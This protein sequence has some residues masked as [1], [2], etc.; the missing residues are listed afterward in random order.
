MSPA[1]AGGRRVPGPRRLP[2]LGPVFPRRRLLGAS[3][4]ALLLFLGGCA[5]RLA[6][7]PRTGRLQVITTTGIL[8][9]LAHNVGGDRIDVVSLV[10]D[11]GDPHSYEA[12]LRDARNVVYADVALSN[13]AML[14][15]QNVIKTLDSNLRDEALNVSLAEDSAKYAAE[16]IP[17]VEDVRLDTVWLGLRASGTGSR[18]GATRSSQVILSA[19]EASGPG[20]LFAYLTGSFGETDIYFDSSDSFQS[21]DGY[22]SDSTTLPA[23]AHTHLSWAFTRPGTY[24]LTLRA[25]LQ[26]EETD[27]PVE[28]G[29]ATYTFAVGVDPEKAAVGAGIRHPVIVRQGHADLTVNVDRRRLE[30][31]HDPQGGGENSQKTYRADQVVVE[32]PARAL[33][34][35]PGGRQYSFLG[36]AGDSV[37]QLAQAVVG[38]HVHGEIDPHLWQNVRNAMA[39]VQL[40]RD[41]FIDADPG[42]GVQ[43]RQNAKSYLAE[44][45]RTDDYVRRTIGR[46]PSSHRHLVTTHDAFAYLAKAYGMTVAGFVTPDPSSEE[47]LS[48]RRKLTSTL[49]TLRVPAVFLEPNLRA[50]SST[51]TEVAAENDIQVRPIYGDTFDDKVTSYVQMMRFNA[52]SLRSGLGG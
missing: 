29:R 20:H 11:S 38:K 4:L 21:G 41:T 42:G 35:I 49:R 46:I 18:Y 34:E 2:G 43:Y 10:P 1:A 40:I 16:I 45:E 9:D 50:R 44:L 15:E 8:R 22:R 24:T 30:L 33:T 13:Y 23:D 14:E 6:L 3:A 17:L 19:V 28:L 37:Y 32:V 47:S 36:H 39:Y 52:D 5:A 31:R 51:L 27:R 26:V 48:D 25:Q 7:N 12:S